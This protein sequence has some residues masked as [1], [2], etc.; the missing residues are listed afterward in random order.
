MLSLHWPKDI[1]QFSGNIKTSDPASWIVLALAVC[2]LALI[3]LA[4]FFR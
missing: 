3:L 4:A 1:E 2:S